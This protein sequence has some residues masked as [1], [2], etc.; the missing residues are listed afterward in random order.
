MVDALE[1]VVEAGGCIVDHHGSDLC[2]ERWFDLVVVLQCDN[3]VL[4]DRL[5][6]RG[7]TIKK[8]QENVECEIMQVTLEE[9]LEDAHTLMPAA[10]RARVRDVRA[11]VAQR[12]IAASR[13]ESRELEDPDVERLQA[14]LHPH[15]F[16]IGNRALRAPE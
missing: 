13:L 11:E 3:T 6:K 5:E 7:Y 15:G 8:I 12:V 16:S 4:Y 9:M 14:L 2:P 10:Y 1:E